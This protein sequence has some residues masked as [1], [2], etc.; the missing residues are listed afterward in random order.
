M[1]SILTPT[2]GRPER[3]R[4][5]VNSVLE[6]ADNPEDVEFIVRIDDDDHSYEGQIFP[7]QV[8]IESGP[9]KNL[10]QCFEWERGKGPF[11]FNGGDDTVFHTK[12]WDTKVKEAFD[13]YP[14]K[15]ALVYG[16]DGNPNETTNI[17]L[18][19][20]HRNWIEATGRY[21]PPFFSGDFVDTWLTEL[22]DGVG[23]RHKIDIYTEHEHPAFGKREQDQTDKD[24][25]EKHFRDDMP[26]L[27]QDTLP[28]RLEDIEK[29]K[30]FIKEFK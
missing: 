6:T 20:V 14:D 3:L 19:F 27:Y 18:G 21:F 9:R 29:L 1:I 30:K 13:Q 26:K 5:F 17:S 24:K 15:I 7:K 10:A 25:W 28:E 16:D 23:R 2:R 12:G 4:K 11:Y 8:K 22:A